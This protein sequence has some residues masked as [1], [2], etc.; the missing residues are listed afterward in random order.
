MAKS[1]NQKISTP[2]IGRRNWSMG[3]WL[4]SETSSSSHSRQG[5]NVDVS[6]PVKERQILNINKQTPAMALVLRKLKELLPPFCHAMA[7]G[8]F[9]KCCS[10][11][12]SVLSTSQKQTPAPYYSSPIF[13]RG[14]SSPVSPSRNPNSPIRA[15]LTGSAME[16]SESNED[17]QNVLNETAV[18]ENNLD[19]FFLLTGVE[20]MYTSLEHANS[21]GFATLMVTCYEQAVKDLQLLRLNMTDAFL[22][23]AGDSVND[24]ASKTASG[25]TV[26]SLTSTLSFLVAFCQ[27]RIQ[28]IQLQSAL[29]HSS[30]DFADMAGL[31]KTLLPNLQRLSQSSIFDSLHT[32]IV[33][34]LGAWASICQTAFSVQHCR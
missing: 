29:W 20:S 22:M 31:F 19:V 23:N 1:G 28:C 13:G 11:L 10:L 14:A 9:I 3:K 30:P 5:Y 25:L 32:S 21:T 18:L 16:R 12:G 15:W 17:S 33:N 2:I 26:A 8:H 7:E 27:A 4:S 34:E 6:P 24:P